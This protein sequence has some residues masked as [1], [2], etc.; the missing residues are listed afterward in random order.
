[1]ALIDFKCVK[2]GNEFFEIISAGGTDKVKCPECGG[3]VERIYKGK[4]YGKSSE[5]GHSG[6]GGSCGS[7]SGCR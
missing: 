6:C 5:G 4:F 2:C 7:C 3:D 1:M